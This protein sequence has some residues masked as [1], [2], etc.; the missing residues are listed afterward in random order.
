MILWMDPPDVHERL[1]NFLTATH[2]AN[3]IQHHASA[4][5]ILIENYIITHKTLT[6]EAFL[7]K[8]IICKQLL[9]IPFRH[10]MLRT[11]GLQLLDA[12]KFCSGW[13]R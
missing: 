7:V 1:V 13:A 2:S 8:S 3:I 4:F 9:P 5:T 10:G 12:H 6:G 11:G